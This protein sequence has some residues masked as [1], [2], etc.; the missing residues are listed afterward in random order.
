MEHDVQLPDEYDQI[1]H[2]LEPFWGMEP[3]DLFLIQAE[4][5][6]KLDSYT[7]GKTSK[8]APVGILTH[9]FHDGRYDQ[10]IAGSHAILELLNKIEHL[11]PEFRFTV[12]PHDGPNLKIGPRCHIPQI[13][14]DLMGLFYRILLMRLFFYS[15]G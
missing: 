3:S 6:T 9:A 8:D 13:Y 2:D 10:L 15:A 12:S 4:L 5:E 11:L 14:S 1:S 7:V